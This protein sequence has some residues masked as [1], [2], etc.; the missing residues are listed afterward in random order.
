MSTDRLRRAVEQS[1]ASAWGGDVALEL[2]DQGGLSERQHVHRFRVRKAPTGSPASVIVKQPRAGDSDRALFFT[3]WACLQLLTELCPEPPAPRLFCGNADPG[4]LVMEDFGSGERLDHALLGSDATHATQMLVALFETIGRMH[5]ATV[6]KR[7]RFDAILEERLGK[8]P[9]RSDRSQRLQA[10]IRDALDR[11]A[12]R[13]HS[14]FLDELAEIARGADSR[15]LET[16]IHGDPC[17][18]NCQWVG[19]RVRLLDFEHGRFGNPFSDACYPIIHFPTCWCM[20]RLPDDVVE[21][22]LEGYRRVV[23]VDGQQFD[24]GMTD[25]SILW[26]WSTFAGWHMPQVLS[27]DH[28][29]GLATV[30]QRILFRFR[31][32]VDR[33]ER[34]GRYPGIAETTR[35]IHEI[36]SARWRDVTDVRLYPAF[37]S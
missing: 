10:A 7:D 17:P 30:R 23:P 5:A 27:E 20:G 22:A 4:F 8:R 14:S 21:Q 18:D 2:G 29:W 26:A 6:G 19:N 35:R 32:L 36:L 13:P 12:L 15:E 33:L 1:L 16:L 24:R 3:E 37:R 31:L 11:L 28:E 34:Q 25:A 9:D